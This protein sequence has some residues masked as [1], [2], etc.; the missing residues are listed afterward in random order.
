MRRRFGSTA[1]LGATPAHRKVAVLGIVLLGLLVG[2]VVI[3]A[4]NM[5]DTHG[6]VEAIAEEAGTLTRLG[7][8]SGSTAA[9]QLALEQATTMDDPAARTPV[10]GVW[11]AATI[12]VVQLRDELATEPATAPLIDEIGPDLDAWLATSYAARGLLD[13]AVPDPAVLRMD[14]VR[15]R[16]DDVSGRLEAEL[17]AASPRL[18][19]RSEQAVDDAARTEYALLLAGAFGLVVGIVVCRASYRA[20]HAQ[21]REITRRDRTRNVELQRRDH[22]ARISRALEYSRDEADVRRVVALAV[23]ELVPE[24]PSELLLADSSHAHFEVASRTRADEQ[25]PGCPVPS[26]DACPAVVRGQALDFDSSR[27]FDACPYLQGRPGGAVSATCIPVAINGSSA[28]VLHSTAADG[29]RI[30]PTDRALLE[31]VA[32]R[33][34][35]RLGVL[36]AFSRSESQAATDPLTG[37]ANRRSFEN[38]ASELLANG[39]PVSVAFGDLDHF[40]SLN[41]RHGHDVGD[42]ALRA[43][44]RT[45][46]QSVRPEDLVARWGGEEF[47]VAFPDTPRHTA[48]EILDRVRRELARV[49]ST[50]GIPSF[51]V[52]FGVSDGFDGD[53]LSSLVDA[54]DRALLRAKTEGRDRVVVSGEGPVPAPSGA[55]DPAR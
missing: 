3:G 48:A 47:V 50:G 7:E 49:V 2:V 44:A 17:A 8:F 10:L 24:R 5:R 27:H 11:D 52:S 20:A 28:G 39:R 26:P 32:S 33:G 54:A 53:D 1:R 15:A 14:E 30:D 55:A 45:L 13:D 23:E 18:T 31:L 16:Y 29:V 51:T 40:K 25:W 35:D 19:G 42:R 36:R 12:R 46:R 9:V 37:L 4:L 43:F 34:G 38:Q 6:E 21:H 22:E 41:D